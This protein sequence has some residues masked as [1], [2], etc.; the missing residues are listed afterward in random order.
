MKKKNSFKTKF[1]I[2]IKNFQ[3]ISEE[4]TQNVDILDLKDPSRGSIGAW[5]ISEIRKTKLFL[6]SKINISATLGDIFDNY[7]FKE[8]AQKFDALNLNFVKFGLLSTS[9]NKLFEKLE[10]I[11]SIKPKTNFVCVV[12]ADQ[13]TSLD[14]V[15]NE[16]ELFK[17]Y[18]VN[19][20]LIDTFRK[21]KGDLMQIC[22]IAFLKELIRKCKEIDINVGL[23]GGVKEYQIKRLIRLQPSIIGFRSAVCT[24]HCRDNKIDDSKIKRLSV[25]FKSPIKSA[26][27]TAGA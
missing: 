4:I 11:Q 8:M 19:T 18:G 14:R 23:A 6:K 22:K 25:Y 13:S 12:F 1:L 17:Y 27:E 2:S 5:Q 10:I 7:E 21:N 3:E 26:I 16:L 9:K 24:Q 15:M 20:I